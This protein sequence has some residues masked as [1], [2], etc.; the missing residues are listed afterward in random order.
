MAKITSAIRNT[1]GYNNP[2]NYQ[3]LDLMKRLL[4]HELLLELEMLIERL[5]LQRLRTKIIGKL[6]IHWH[7]QQWWL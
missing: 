7:H 1:I 6:E 2:S 4:H 5:S 3:A